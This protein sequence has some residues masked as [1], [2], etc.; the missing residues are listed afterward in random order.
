MDGRD[1]TRHKKLR[2]LHVFATVARHRSLTAAAVALGISQPAMSK[3]LRELESQVGSALFDR[4]RELKLL[5]QGE[6]LLR[7]V[8]RVL[9]ELGRAGDEMKELAL[10]RAG[11]VRVGTVFGP[12]SIFVPRAVVTFSEAAPSVEVFLYEDT[13]DRLLPRLQTGELDV[14]VCRLEEQAL[15][16]AVSSEVLYDDP[17]RIVARP[18]HPLARSRRLTWAEVHECAWI[19]PVRGAPM[20]LRIEQAFAQAGLSLPARRIESVSPISS[21]TLVRETDRLAVMSSDLAHY[22]EDAGLVRRLP[23]AV[24]QGVGPVGMLWIDGPVASTVER[25]LECLRRQAR[26]VHRRSIEQPRRTGRTRS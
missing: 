17:A 2:H 7:R 14:I 23:L 11:S 15:N 21:L 18:G 3:W 13:V 16:A 22:F 8:E 10:G 5:P 12:G 19:L 9:G 20:R 25:L 4:G 6:V 1:W 24:E 26:E